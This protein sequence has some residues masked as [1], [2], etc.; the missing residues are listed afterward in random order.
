M[1]NKYHQKHKQQKDD[2]TSTRM[3]EIKKTIQAICVNAFD[4]STFSG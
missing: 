2:F 1:Y 4:T 3:R